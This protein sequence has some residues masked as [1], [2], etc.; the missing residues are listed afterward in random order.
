MCICI[1]KYLDKAYF[2]PNHDCSIQPPAI[3]ISSVVP[4][5]QLIPSCLLLSLLTATFFL[6]ILQGLLDLLLNG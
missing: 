2:L 1:F 6:D 4:Q 5:F 3:L